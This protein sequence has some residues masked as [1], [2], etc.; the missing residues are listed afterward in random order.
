[1]LDHCPLPNRASHAS[2]LGPK[3]AVDGRVSWRWTVGINT[4]PGVWPVTVTCDHKTARTKFTV[5]P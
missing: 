5:T 1:V 4:T 2:F 3:R